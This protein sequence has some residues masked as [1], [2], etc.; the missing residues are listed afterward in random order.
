MSV[1]LSLRILQSGPIFGPLDLPAISGLQSFGVALITLLVLMLRPRGL[2]GGREITEVAPLVAD[3]EGVAD[4]R[5][6]S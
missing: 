5:S 4:A 2:T 1:R 6:A 3:R